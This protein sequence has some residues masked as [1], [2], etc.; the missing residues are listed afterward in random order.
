MKLKLTITMLDGEAETVAIRP[1]TQV[2]FESHF[3]KKLTDSDA[4]GMT[5][6]YW[7]GWKSSKAVTKFDSWLDEIDG[8]EV[9]SD[10]DGDGV[11]P[12][13]L[14]QPTGT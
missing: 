4:I 7:L 2:D 8:V 1:K 13:D 14:N 11:D 5:E 6:L 10:D 12:L 3:K 9:F